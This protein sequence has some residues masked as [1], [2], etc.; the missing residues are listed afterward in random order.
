MDFKS[1]GVPGQ[2]LKKAQARGLGML[3]LW[4]F[5][6]KIY[7]SL[8]SAVIAEKAPWKKKSVMFEDHKTLSL[9]AVLAFGAEK[10]Y[11]TGPGVLWANSFG[12][13]KSFLGEGYPTA[14]LYICL[15]LSCSSTLTR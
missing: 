5:A 3:Y 6:G 15:P 7:S 9:L 10:L 11:S 4:K 8:S 13:P 14:R 2:A 1:F 12:R